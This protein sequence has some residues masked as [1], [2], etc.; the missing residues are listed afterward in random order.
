MGYLNNITSK[1][2][3]VVRVR[4]IVILYFK[5]ALNVKNGTG[6]SRQKSFILGNGV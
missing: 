2:R 1:I 6:M 5:I 4:G 3:I